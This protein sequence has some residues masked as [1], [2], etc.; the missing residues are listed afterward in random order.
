MKNRISRISGFRFFIGTLLFL[1]L[2]GTVQAQDSLAVYLEWAGKN[3][4]GLQARYLE[5]AAELERVT[6]AGA[7]PDPTV[8]W[9]FFLKPMALMEG[10]QIGNIQAMQMFPWFGALKAAKNEASQMALM[11]YEEA[12]DARNLLYRQ[13]KTAWLGVY[14]KKKEM[15]ILNENMTLLRALE[16]MALTK[17]SNTK[18][19]T[20]SQRFSTANRALAVPSATGAAT[21]GGMPQGALNQGATSLSPMEMGGGSSE[22]SSKGS[23]MVDVLR[24]QMEMAELANK[25]ALTNDLLAV[26]TARFN[27]LLNRSSEMAVHVPDTLRPFAL[28]FAIDRMSDSLKNNPMLRMVIAQ[29]AAAEAQSVMANKMGKP[30]MGIGANFMLIEK[31]SGNES[32]MNGKDMIM[33]MVSVTIP[34][35]NKKYKSMEREATLKVEAARKSY[36]NG[37]NSLAISF[38]ES[39][40]QYTDAGRR[41]SL[42]QNQ[43]AL[44][45]TSVQLLM[46]AFSVSEADFE[47]VL[48]MQTQLLD[49]GLKELAALTDLN[50]SAA[51]L[52]YLIGTR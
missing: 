30:M 18:N 50:V 5:Y 17:Y 11:K 45:K 14:Q 39:V 29:R 26:E 25:I 35:F 12:S 8:Q 40:Q 32:M 9:G 37:L 52:E 13:V 49:Y 15:T 1:L 42:Y 44:A 21:M 20:S 4:P 41:R 16:T 2:G 33:P 27:R 31:R 51:Q 19:G 23:G 48:R 34:F 43:A 22:M 3:N 46:T 38:D 36:E 47:E 10:N 6:Q 7:L 24:V 28:S